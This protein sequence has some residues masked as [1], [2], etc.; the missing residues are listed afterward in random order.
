VFQALDSCFDAFSLREP[1]STPV[2]VRGRLSL[3]NA[4]GCD[5]PSRLIAHIGFLF[6]AV[7]GQGHLSFFNA[8][9]SII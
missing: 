1:V 2:Q 7:A 8:P 3:E 5:A 9:D 4:L 6:S